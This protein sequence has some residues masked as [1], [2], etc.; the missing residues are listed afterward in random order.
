MLTP[1]VSG[2]CIAFGY[3]TTTSMCISKGEKADLGAFGVLVAVSGVLCT[4]C[5]VVLL[6]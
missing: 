6:V 4:G 1:P 3:Q 2:W 5:V